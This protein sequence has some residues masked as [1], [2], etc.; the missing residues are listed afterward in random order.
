M[1]APLLVGLVMPDRLTR[2]ML[3]NYLSES[4]G[5]RPT[6]LPL[7]PSDGAPLCVD[8]VLVARAQLL[9]AIER[10]PGVPLLSLQEGSDPEEMAEALHEGANGVLDSSTSLHEVQEA[11]Q[12]VARGQTWLPSSH[13][14]AVLAALTGNRPVTERKTVQ[15]L[16]PRERQV[17]M[18]MGHGLTR[19]EIADEL[20]VSPHTARTHV[21]NVLLKLGVHSQV[22]VGAVAR[23]AAQAGWL[24]PEPP[25]EVSR[26][27]PPR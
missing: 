19:R 27:R 3:L 24:E 1:T 17:M 2:Q 18:L 23:R 14:T 8:V 7:D 25:T 20:V 26:P 21:Q 4:R 11:V 13:V 5:L 16:T 22:A 15:S 10:W 6:Q 12:A 9:P